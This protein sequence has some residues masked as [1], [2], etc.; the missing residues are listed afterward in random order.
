MRIHVFI[1]ES[2]A[3]W[4]LSLERFAERLTTDWPNA[5]AA[6]NTDD[7]DSYVDFWPAFGGES[8]TFGGEDAEGTYFAGRRPQ[9]VCDVGRIAGIDDW[10]PL[11]EWFLGLLPDGAA[12]QTFLDDVA[13]PQPLPL[14]STAADIAR[15]LN[16]LNNSV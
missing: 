5:E 4:D 9:L 2:G 12:V 1:D 3:P 14:S 13:I 15:I 7:S 10:A 11:I 16:D 6:V 8:P